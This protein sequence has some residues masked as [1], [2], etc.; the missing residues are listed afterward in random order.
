MTKDEQAMKLLALAAELN[1]RLAEPDILLDIY[2][3]NAP[4]SFHLDE[5]TF[6]AVAMLARK[7]GELEV[8]ASYQ[9][10]CFHGSLTVGHVRFMVCHN[11]L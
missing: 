10:A 5:K 11:L 2:S 1:T 8:V 6:A 4:L 3:V 9:G 7:R